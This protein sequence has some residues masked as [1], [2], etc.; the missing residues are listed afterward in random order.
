MKVK[1][2][3]V[4][5]KKKHSP[6]HFWCQ[7][8]RRQGWSWLSSLRPKH[9]SQ[10]ALCSRSWRVS[11][12]CWACPNLHPTSPCSSS[13]VALRR[14]W[15]TCCGLMLDYAGCFVEMPRRETHQCNWTMFLLTDTSTD[16]CFNVIC[17][18]SVWLA[19]KFYIQSYSPDPSPKKGQ[20][21]S[22]LL[23][24]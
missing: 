20:V 8:W 10:A 12:W 6:Q 22:L 18:I 14:R 5:I 17:I 21:F 9:R 11:V 1:T 15:Y 16:L 4:I 13:S 19:F 3:P 2:H 7:S 24:L 23:L